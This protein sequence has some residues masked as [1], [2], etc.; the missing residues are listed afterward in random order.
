MLH[1][2][3][4]KRLTIFLAALFLW[5]GIAASLRA[6]Q[7]AI[8][9]AQPGSP[10]APDEEEEQHEEQNHKTVRLAEQLAPPEPEAVRETTH[11]RDLRT[12]RRADLAHVPAPLDR[13]PNLPR[14]LI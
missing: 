2:L 4:G 13:R 14:R 11:E 3:A 10:Q 9:S 1:R 7:Q 8:F 5:S 12:H 6:G